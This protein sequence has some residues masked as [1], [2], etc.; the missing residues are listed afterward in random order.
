MKEIILIILL[1]VKKPI[2]AN[3]SVFTDEFK[4]SHKA[5]KFKVDDRVRI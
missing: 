2:C 5:L 4:V 1:F 3:Y